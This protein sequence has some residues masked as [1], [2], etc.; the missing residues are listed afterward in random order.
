MDS[1]AIGLQIPFFFFLTFFPLFNC[2]FF[3]N[4][5]FCKSELKAMPPPTARSPN[6]T[7]LFYCSFRG[8]AASSPSLNEETKSPGWC[9]SVG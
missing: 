4:T 9:G 5:N 3:Y 7:L 6:Y 8:K 2:I 1:V